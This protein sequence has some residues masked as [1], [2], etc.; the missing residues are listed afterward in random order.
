M[1]VLRKLIIIIILILILPFFNFAEEQNSD[2]VCFY[3]A[4][5]Y[6]DST[7]VIKS[8][9]HKKQINNLKSGNRLK[10]YLEP[11]QNAYIYLILYDSQNEL[12]ILF[13]DAQKDFFTDY[14]TGCGY[15]VP[16]KKVWFYLKNDGGMEL[17]H[18]IVSRTRCTGL[19]L[20]IKN[21]LSLLQKQSVSDKM[22]NKAKQAVLE[23]IRILKKK[24]SVFQGLDERPL[25]IAGD[26]RGEET[27]H[28]FVYRIEVENFY[29]KTFRV[30]H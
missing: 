13:P 18:F 17:F 3:L 8:I 23:E 16:E 24:H 25:S 26:Y 6:K 22:I 12:F 9:D 2:K 5:V 28:Q 10:I 14:Q 20:V 1:C 15:Y 29:A 4:F 21:Y 11:L 27:I 19:E 30:A 7:G